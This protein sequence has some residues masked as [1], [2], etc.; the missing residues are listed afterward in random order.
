MCLAI[1]SINMI[2]LNTGHKSSINQNSIPIS[3]L[4]FISVLN[5]TLYQKQQFKNLFNKIN[6]KSYWVA[7]KLFHSL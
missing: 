3:G 7:F 1:H 4:L 5:L 2:Y 6:P